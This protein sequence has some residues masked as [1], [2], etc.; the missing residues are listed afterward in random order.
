[1]H[2]ETMLCFSTYLSSSCNLLLKFLRDWPSNCQHL[3]PSEI[4]PPAA[5]ARRLARHLRTVEGC[6]FVIANTH[7]RLIED[8]EVSNA[9]QQDAERVDLLLGGHDHDVVCRFLGDKDD[10]PETIIEG[11]SNEEVVLN[12]KVNKNLSGDIRIVKSGTDWRG[13]SEV[14]LIVDRCANTGK[15]RLIDINGRLSLET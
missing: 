5:V 10:D 8:L 15:A 1:M 7:M 3:P 2:W 4:L 13:Y 6:D 9:T 11:K 12:G 14:E